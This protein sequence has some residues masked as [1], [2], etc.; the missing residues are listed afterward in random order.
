MKDRVREHD[1]SCNRAL[2]GGTDVNIVSLSDIQL[3]TFYR[4]LAKDLL[5][6]AR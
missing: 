2:N 1:R 6:F 3:E 4:F 5:T